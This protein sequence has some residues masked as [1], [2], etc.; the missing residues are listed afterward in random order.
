MTK[1]TQAEIAFLGLLDFATDNQL[2]KLIKLEGLSEHV[3][4]RICKVSARRA[5]SPEHLGEA[6]EMFDHYHLG[7]EYSSGVRTHPD[8]RV[9]DVGRLSPERRAFLRDELAGGDE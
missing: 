9:I 3:R 8:L 6:T 5:R 4:R 2:R 7:N 1:F